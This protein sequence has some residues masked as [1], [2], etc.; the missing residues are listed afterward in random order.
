VLLQA[1]LWQVRVNLREL[2]DALRRA[3]GP[4]AALARELERE[5]G[6]RSRS[7]LF[8]GRRVFV[9]IADMLAGYPTLALVNCAIFRRDRSAEILIAHRRMI[10]RQVVPRQ[11]CV[12]M[13]N[14][15]L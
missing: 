1:A 14:H 3:P 4:A 12:A 15:S 5:L 10:P 9:R 2:A 6:R 13:I 8:H 7:C 11:Y